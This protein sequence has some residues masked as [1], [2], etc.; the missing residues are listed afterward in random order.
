MEQVLHAISWRAKAE[1]EAEAE[2]GVVKM[3]HYVQ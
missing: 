1:T 3:K 2:E